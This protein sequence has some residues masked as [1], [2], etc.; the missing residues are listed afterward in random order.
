MSFLTNHQLSMKLKSQSLSLLYVHCHY[1][2]FNIFISY[3]LFILKKSEK[4]N[5]IN[6]I[7]ERG[8]TCDSSPDTS[9]HSWI[10]SYRGGS[11]WPG[12]GNS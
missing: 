4:E 8:D 6:K 11:V 3:A 1:T 5:P 2:F 7:K 10:G 9:V 12:I